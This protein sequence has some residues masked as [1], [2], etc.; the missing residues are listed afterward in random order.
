MKKFIIKLSIATSMLITLLLLPASTLV[1][2]EIESIT[3]TGHSFFYP[4]NLMIYDLQ[5]TKDSRHLLSAGQDG[6][7]IVWD[8]ASG[9]KIKS[10]FNQVDNQEVKGIDLS[11][12]EK[13]IV[14]GSP[15][16]Q[17]LQMDYETGEILDRHEDKTNFADLPSYP[18]AVYMGDGRVVSAPWG[19]SAYK[20]GQMLPDKEKPWGGANNGT[21][22]L[23]RSPDRTMIAITT[24][25]KDRKFKLFSYPKFKKIKSIK[26]NDITLTPAAISK[27]NR[28]VAVED[29]TGKEVWILD[30]EKKYKVV[31]KVPMWRG[32]NKWDSFY[33]DGLTFSP[34]EKNLFVG[35]TFLPRSGRSGMKN[36]IQR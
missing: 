34:D 2:Q 15:F 14:L 30:K 1:A 36:Y 7:V 3:Q 23:E 16:S 11:K 8:V 10:F 12:D 27:S 28:Y 6:Q 33:I 17:I 24:S 18:G 4:Q 20:P 32:T 29:G 21:I 13:K 5:F 19:L 35:M 22:S 26:L 31:Y 9:R 25:W